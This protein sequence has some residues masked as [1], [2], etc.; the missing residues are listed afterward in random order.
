MY[1]TSKLVLAALGLVAADNL[2][3]LQ[4]FSSEDFSEALELNQG[5][6]QKVTDYKIDLRKRYEAG[7]LAADSDAYKT[8]QQI[9]NE[10]GFKTSQHQVVTEDGYILNVWRIDGPLV[11]GETVRDTTKKPILL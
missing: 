1:K 7:E 11:P 6:Y 8:M 9:C 2:E 10:N 5:K 4:D 3:N